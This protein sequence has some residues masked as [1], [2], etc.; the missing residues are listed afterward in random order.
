MMLLLFQMIF[1]FLLFPEW[2]W[3]CISCPLIGHLVKPTISSASGDDD[4]VQDRLIDRESLLLDQ[5]EYK[6]SIPDFIFEIKYYLSFIEIICIYIY[7]YIYIY[8]FL[9]SYS[10]QTIFNVI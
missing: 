7:I 3:T 2:P 1:S 9:F 10:K 6:P 8:I 5:V 4:T